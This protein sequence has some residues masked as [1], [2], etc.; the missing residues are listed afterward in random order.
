M[1]VPPPIAA[2]WT[3]ATI[4]LSKSTSAFINRACGESPGPGGFFRKS[5]I[6]LPA[7]NE[8][9]APCQ[10]TTRVCSSLA[11]SVKISARVTYMLEV[12]AFFFAGRFNR[13]RS[14]LAERSVIISSI[15]HSRS[16]LMNFCARLGPLRRAFLCFRNGAALAQAVDFARAK[17]QLLENRLVVFSK[18][19]GPLGRDFRNAM[20]IDGTAD[21][22]GE[23]SAG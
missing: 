15:V 18:C 10:S 1:V 13:T 4:G 8:S 11:A 7:Q 20:H 6:S 5:S 3:A 21:R 2:P 23:L 9:P 17:A 22:R 14:T 12:I 19:W 16:G